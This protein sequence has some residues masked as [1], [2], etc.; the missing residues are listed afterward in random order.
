MCDKPFVSI[1]VPVY[2]SEEYLTATLDAFAAQTYPEVEFLLIDDGSVD[3]SGRLCDE[4]AARDGRFRVI[5]KANGGVS[6]ARNTGLEMAKGQLIGF[7]DS[8][9]IIKNTYIQQLAENM[10][11]AGADIS[12]CRNFI[13]KPENGGNFPPSPAESELLLFTATQSIQNALIDRYYGGG[14]WGCLIKRSLVENVRFDR[15]LF[16]DEDLFFILQAMVQAKR[17]CYTKNQMYNYISHS[18]GISRGKFSERHLTLYPAL[19][20]ITAFLK[21]NSDFDE[22]EPYLDAHIVT[23]NYL[24]L[25]R[26][27][28]DKQ[29]QKKYGRISQKNIRS[30]LNWRSIRFLG[31]Y[32]RVCAILSAVHYRLYILAS[33][34]M[35]RSK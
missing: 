30:H 1:I 12:I 32:A 22:I 3:A 4:Y 15:E 9:D 34:L 7:V 10:A 21:A 25:R 24:Q 28:Y 11:S 31:N 13:S 29:A 26:M 5:H 14:C 17:I 20:R 6:S 16:L 18:N 23:M 27:R 2:N 35:S 33:R 8:D 19:E